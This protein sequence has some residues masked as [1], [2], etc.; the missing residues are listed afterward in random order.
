M[1][2]KPWSAR[3]SASGAVNASTPRKPSSSPRIRRSR[4]VE[5]TDFDATRIGS[6][7][8]WA[9]IAAALRRIASRSTNANGGAT[10]AKIES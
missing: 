2:V 4:A 3:C 9:S 10:P 8:A 6:P 7:P 1:S 5:R